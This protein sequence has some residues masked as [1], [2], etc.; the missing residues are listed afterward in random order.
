M[1][2]LHTGEPRE[3]EVEVGAGESRTPTPCGAK[4]RQEVP[5]QIDAGRLPDEADRLARES[6]VIA[7][8]QSVQI[9][10]EPPAAREHTLPKILRLE[11]L[12][13]LRVACAI[14]EERRDMRPD[15]I[16]RWSR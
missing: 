4:V 6:D 11:E 14:A 15:P 3:L 10:E 13:G 5:L 16:G 12:E 1:R 7:R 2:Q 8:L 9:L